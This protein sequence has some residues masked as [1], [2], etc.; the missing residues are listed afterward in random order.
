MADIP[1]K[2]KENVRAV[3]LSKTDGKGVLVNDFL[4]DYKN[5]LKEPLMYKSLGYSN[6]PEFLKAIPDICRYSHELI[7]SAVLTI[8]IWL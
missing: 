8:F 2:I 6:L 1:D 3:L 5:I 4:R 7:N